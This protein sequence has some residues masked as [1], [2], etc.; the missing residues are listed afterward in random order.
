MPNSTPLRAIVH[1]TVEA[2]SPSM[3]RAAAFAAHIDQARKNWSLSRVT[4]RMIGSRRAASGTAATS[5]AARR[6]ASSPVAAALRMCISSPMVKACAISAARSIGPSRSS[7]ADKAG[8]TASRIQRRP[9]SVS[10][11]WAPKRS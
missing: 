2:S 1:T 7:T 9:F 4:R 11:P 8:A 10:G 3:D 5:G 6:R